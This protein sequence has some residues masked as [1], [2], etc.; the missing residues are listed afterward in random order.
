MEAL[1]VVALNETFRLLIEPLFRRVAKGVA[2]VPEWQTPHT[3]GIRDAVVG[4][5]A[6]I[7]DHLLKL[8]KDKLHIAVG[9]LK[10]G[11]AVMAQQAPDPDA[12]MKDFE[13]AYEN[14]RAAFVTVSTLPDKILATKV[15]VAA[16]WFLH[17]Q[18]RGR[19]DTAC[20]KAIADLKALYAD[21]ELVSAVA[22]EFSQSNSAAPCVLRIGFFDKF[23]SVQHSAQ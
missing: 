3:S 14:S 18:I 5:L 16:A 2:S 8:G 13:L 22:S 12:A 1:P 9:H 10:T 19:K 23:R 20:T 11:V 4:D 7:K 21:P 15:S 6:L 17:S